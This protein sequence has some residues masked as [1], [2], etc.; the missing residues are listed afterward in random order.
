VAI[1]TGNHTENFRDIVALFQSR[2]AVRIV[3]MAELPLTLMHLL[4][5]DAER[6]TLG[7]RAQETIRSQMGAT[8]RTLQALKTLISADHDPQPASAQAAHT[9]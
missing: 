6:R 5:N 8:S 1:V 9:D 2:D 7:R 4:A 3:G